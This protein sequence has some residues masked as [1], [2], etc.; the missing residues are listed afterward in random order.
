MANLIEM[1]PV[2]IY[3]VLDNRNYRL[4]K[5]GTL[6]QATEVLQDVQGINLEKMARIQNQESLLFMLVFMDFVYA[7][8]SIAN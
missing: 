7:L 5:K 2:C 4:G 3:S 6:A 8:C 1:G